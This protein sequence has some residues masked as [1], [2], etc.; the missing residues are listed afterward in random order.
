MKLK[1]SYDDFND[2]SNS[3]TDKYYGGTGNTYESAE[4]TGYTYT[5]PGVD[6][7]DAQTFRV[8][9]NAAVSLREQSVLV[10]SLFFMAVALVIS[11]IAAFAGLAYGRVNPYGYFNMMM[12]ALVLEIVVYLIALFGL[13]KGNA[14]VGG[15]GF[16]AYSIVSGL[17]MSIIFFAYDLGS[18]VAIFF[19]TAI[20]FVAVAIYGYTTSTNL[21]ALQSFFLMGLVGLVGVGIMNIFMQSDAVANVAAVV[22]VVLFA[23]ITAYDI[24]RIKG[25]NVQ[26][27]DSDENTVAMFGGL[28]LYLDFVNIFLKLLRLF[29]RS[30]RN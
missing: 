26:Y 29:A 15:I 14:V 28:M 22:G 2:G 17:T 20:M 5:S 27:G 25:L 1:D 19:I 21:S 6:G 7:Y 18:I 30:S 10:K 12:P 4:D 13:N 16:V 23:G 24:Q 8:S 9:S 3:D 11:A